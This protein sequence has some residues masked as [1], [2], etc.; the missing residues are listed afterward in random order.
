MESVQ[1]ATLT[2]ETGQTYGELTTQAQYPT[3]ILSG[4]VKITASVTAYIVDL[5]TGNLSYDGGS[6]LSVFFAPNKTGTALKIAS[7]KLTEYPAL[8]LSNVDTPASGDFSFAAGETG[9]LIVDGA[10]D[11]LYVD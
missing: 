11:T 3:E 5:N 2:M 1:S 9:T 10:L 7:A 6:P 8:D 4:Q